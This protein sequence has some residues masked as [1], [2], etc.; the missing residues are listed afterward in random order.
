MQTL[1]RARWA[2]S[3]HGYCRWLAGVLGEQKVGWLSTAKGRGM[4]PETRGT[5]PPG[6]NDLVELGLGR[7]IGH[8]R[9]PKKAPMGDPL[10][11]CSRRS[12]WNGRDRTVNNTSEAAAAGSLPLGG[13]AVEMGWARSRLKSVPLLLAVSMPVQNVWAHTRTLEV[14]DGLTGRGRG[15]GEMGEGEREGAK[16]ARVVPSRKPG[17]GEALEPQVTCLPKTA[18]THYLPA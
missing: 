8:K 1:E 12:L 11:T 6:G 10:S 3:K 14:G 7:S 4:T 13:D 16:L 17:D 18:L 2:G 5:R 9:V 15:L